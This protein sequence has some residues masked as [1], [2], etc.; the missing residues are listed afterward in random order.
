M[1]T[2]LRTELKGVGRL[3][4]MTDVN[5][6]AMDYYEGQDDLSAM[7]AASLE[8]RARILH[9]MGE[10][11]EKRGDMANALEKFTEAHRVTG[12]LLARD[13]GNPDRIFAHAQSENWLGHLAYWRK[14]YREAELRTARNKGLIE[15]LMRHPNR[16][17][18][19]V[20]HAGYS[21]GSDCARLITTKTKPESALQEC[22]RALAYIEELRK[23]LPDDRQ[24]VSDLANRHAWLADAYFANQQERKGFAHRGEQLR[25]VKSLVEDEPD[26]LSWREQWAVTQLSYA[27][28]LLAHQRPTEAG[29]YAR[30]SA[31]IATELVG[32]DPANAKYTEWKRRSANLIK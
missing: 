11:D 32:H 19:W 3:D 10:D 23:I 16:Q 27:E 30:N 2:D 18:D 21:H 26:N 6:R 24:V 7:P 9:A 4:V 14:D 13:P 28:L 20:R 17:A 31:E 22:A 5:E 1:L 29:T 8:R 15:R 12:T 25:L